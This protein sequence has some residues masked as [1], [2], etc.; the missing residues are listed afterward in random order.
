M[1]GLFYLLCVLG[2]WL[3]SGLV[4]AVIGQAR[5]RVGAGFVLGLLLGPIGWIC[6]VAGPDNRQ[7]CPACRSVVDAAASICAACRTPLR[8]PAGAV[9]LAP[10]PRIRRS[11]M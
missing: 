10:D 6:I 5:N 4:G 11:S 7:R 3:S 9:R 8:L 1:I 2:A